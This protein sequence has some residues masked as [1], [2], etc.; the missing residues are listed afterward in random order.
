MSTT[1]ANAT[2]TFRWAA[3]FKLDFG[4]FQGQS[5]DAIATSEN[6][7]RYLDN[8]N[9]KISHQNS[10]VA[11]AVIAYLTDPTIAKDLSDLVGARRERYE[12]R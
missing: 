4:P 12:Q 7:L 8:L 2:T 6:G 5:L 10:A 9:G 1:T 11:R 3:A